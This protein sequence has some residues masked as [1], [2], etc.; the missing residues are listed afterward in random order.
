[1]DQGCDIIKKLLFL[2]PINEFLEVL[3]DKKIIDKMCN[4]IDRRYRQKGYEIYYLVFSDKIVDFPKID[5]RDKIIK[6]NFTF[7][8]HT[9]PLTNEEMDKVDSKNIV[10]IKYNNNIFHHIF[11]DNDAIKKELGNIDELVICGFHSNSC[12]EKAAEY[13]YGEGI[14]TLID[15]DLTQFFKNIS[16]LYYFDERTYNLANLLEYLDGDFLSRNNDLPE[17]YSAKNLYNEPYYKKNSFT[18]TITKEEVLRM[19]VKK[20]LSKQK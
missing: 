20:E 4:T 5:K 14:N 1:M 16:K 6:T 12:V 17:K 10:S 11:A 19:L 13:F 7:E 8:R 15:L 18:P 3:G 9:T 2:Y